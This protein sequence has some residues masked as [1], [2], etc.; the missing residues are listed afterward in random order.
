MLPPVSTCYTSINSQ[1]GDYMERNNYSSHG[2]RDHDEEQKENTQHP[3]RLPPR[4][5]DSH[6][7][8]GPQTLR[9][10]AQELEAEQQLADWR[11]PRA[12]DS[13]RQT[14]EYGDESDPETSAGRVSPYYISESK[15]STHRQSDYARNSNY[16]RDNQDYRRRDSDSFRGRDPDVVQNR[17]ESQAGP[18]RRRQDHA[19]SDEDFFLDFNE[20]NKREQRPPASRDPER[21]RRSR[22]LYRKKK[23]KRRILIAVTAVFAVLIVGG[24]LLLSYLTS[25][26]RLGLSGETV[27]EDLTLPPL[28]EEVPQGWGL[29]DELPDASEGVIVVPGE[30]S[31][32]TTPITGIGGGAPHPATT[33]EAAET[34]NVPGQSEEEPTGPTTTDG[35]TPTTTTQT[36]TLPAELHDSTRTW[37]KDIMNI[38]LL[39][40]D[41]RDMSN[42]NTR[43]DTMMVLTIDR[44]RNELKLTSFQRDMLV[45]IPGHE[46]QGER[47]LNEAMYF[48]PQTSIAA[49]N[50]Y[51]N[52]DIDDFVVVNISGAEKII[53]AVGGIRVDIPTDPDV[54]EYYNAVIREQNWMMDVDNP[55]N[56]VSYFDEGGEDILVKGRQAIAYARMREVDDY[57]RMGRQQEVI[58]KLYDKMLSSDVLTMLNTIKTSFDQ[59]ATSY[60]LPDLLNLAVT[61]AP[62]MKQEVQQLQ[63]PIPGTY[64]EDAGDI[65]VNRVNFNLNIPLIHEFLYEE[66]VPAFNLVPVVSNTPPDLTDLREMPKRLVW[67]PIPAGFH[68]IG[69]TWEQLQF[70][71]W[72]LPEDQSR[73][74]WYFGPTEVR[75]LDNEL[76]D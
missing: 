9:S 60:T 72:K 29:D 33:E 50:Y 37:N 76:P 23:R 38:L 64:W 49:I 26:A 13:T 25:G 42:L 74:Y 18:Q 7:S 45:F 32:P 27:R 71:E 46:D 3:K 44:V 12:V 8:F 51:F 36:L 63:V 75:D 39:G 54:L 66:D 56:Y 17:D 4:K 24:V 52:M 21:L 1:L 10:R 70:T 15:H 53:D 5:R 35:P 16:S 62:V 40:V 14:S 48:G 73:P 61:I 19:V 11:N 65:W 57:R 55:E 58:M 34:E 69:M 22:E 41:T 67:D 68:P 2:D 43:S 20:I 59:M 6:H 30:T 47:K 28:G 31:E